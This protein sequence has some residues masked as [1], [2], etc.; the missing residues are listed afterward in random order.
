VVV[1]VWEE[2]ALASVKAIPTLGVALL[3]LGLGWLLGNGI[4]SRWEEVKVRRAL[5]LAALER[6]Y[7]LYG[8]FYAVWKLWSVYKNPTQG[9]NDE[10]DPSMVW[11]LLERAAEVEGGFESILVRLTQEPDVQELAS[12]R[13][14]YQC[15]R[16]SIRSDQALDWKANPS[17]GEPALKYKEFKRLASRVAH[18]LSYTTRGIV[19]RPPL[20]SLSEA[21]KALVG[22]TSVEFRGNWWARGTGP[23][24]S[25]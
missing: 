8:E 10:R 3:T 19:R 13:E 23:G 20:P 12:F 21:T 22:V 1:R 7:Q 16:E 15:L 18:L 2:L 25:P 17:K 6:F 14:S 4:T 9:P 11:G 5:Q 24:P